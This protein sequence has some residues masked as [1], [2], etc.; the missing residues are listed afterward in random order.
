MAHIAS[1]LGIVLVIATS[2]FATA[3]ATAQAPS[4]A[5]IVKLPDGTVITVD[6]RPTFSMVVVRKPKVATKVSC[7]CNEGASASKV[8]QEPSAPTCVCQN[9]QPTVGCQ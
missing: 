9:R 4:A 7:V 5:K 6:R 1:E 3:T 2:V 8:C